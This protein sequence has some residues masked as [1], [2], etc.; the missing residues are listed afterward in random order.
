VSS[1][2]SEGLWGR[3][4]G[5]VGS[6]SVVSSSS[7]CPTQASAKVS[8]WDSGNNGGVSNGSSSHFRKSRL[9]LEILLEGLEQLNDILP[10]NNALLKLRRR[11]D[12]PLAIMHYDCTF[13]KEPPVTA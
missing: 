11:I 2:E 10:I 8:C 5:V 12:P 1:V 7:A 13:A 9:H 4:I 6:R 3:G